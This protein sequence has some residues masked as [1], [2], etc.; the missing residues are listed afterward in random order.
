MPSF[1]FRFGCLR[2]LLLPLS[3]LLNLFFLA[4]ILGH[5]LLGDAL[6]PHYPTPLARALAHLE[7]SLPPEDAATFR[8]IMVKDAPAYLPAARQLEAA[9][10]GVEAAILAQPVDPARLHKAFATWHAAWDGFFDALSGP[11]AEA[12]VQLSPE[13]RRKLIAARRSEHM[14]AL[15]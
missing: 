11:L 14:G 3:V 4:L 15:H 10:G 6:A 5:L 13:G 1:S 12:V 7:A 2:R 8:R 9:R